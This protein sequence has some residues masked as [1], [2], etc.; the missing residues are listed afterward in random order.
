MEDPGGSVGDSDMATENS[1]EWGGQEK[2]VG[3]F[4]LGAGIYGVS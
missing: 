2:C 4:L 3:I 1:Q